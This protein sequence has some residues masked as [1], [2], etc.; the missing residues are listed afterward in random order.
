MDE[1]DGGWYD[2]MYNN[3]ELV[4]DHPAYFARWAE[5]SERARRHEPCELDVA[6]GDAAGEKL[7]VFPAP[8]AGGPVLV[9]VHGGY[10][11]ALDKRDHSFLAP[12]FTRD[13]ACV[14]VP[15]YA[16]CPAVTIPQITRQVARAVAWTWHNAHRFGGDPGRMVVAG[17]SAGGQLAAMMLAWQWARQEPALPHDTVRSALA[18]SGLHDLDPIMRTPFLQPSL[19]LT[20]EQVAEASPARLPAPRGGTLYTVVGGDESPEYHRQNRLVQEAWGAQRVPICEALPGLNHFSML[21]ALVEPSHR[22]HQLALDLL[23]G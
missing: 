19:Q 22:L 21:E 13:G 6:Y 16:L 2:R 23:R 10:W 18:I 1:H 7:D 4:P 8:Q 12:A 11:R 14:V 3:R 5:L 17:H 20:A 9:F 15:N